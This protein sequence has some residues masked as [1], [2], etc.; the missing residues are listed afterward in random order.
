MYDGMEVTIGD[1]W[2][3]KESSWSDGDFEIPIT[4]TNI[5]NDANN[6]SLSAR[7]TW[8]PEGIA[9]LSSIGGV[10]RMRP[11]VSQETYL[12]IP[13]RGYGVYTVELFDMLRHWQRGNLFA[14]P[15]IVAAI[16]LPITRAD[17][18][19]SGTA[20]QNTGESFYAGV[21]YAGIPISRLL[22]NHIDDFIETFGFSS[23]EMH[24]SFWNEGDGIYFPDIN[25]NPNALISSV[26]FQNYRITGI[27]FQPDALELKRIPFNR[28]TL[29]LLSAFGRPALEGEG[30]GEFEGAN[31]LIYDF[32]GYSVSIW[33]YDLSDAPF[34]IYAQLN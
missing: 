28:A 10:S 20:N 31:F 19:A 22:G 34:A 17:T 3:F 9:I 25:F 6:L 7:S 2:I 18:F 8:C 1:N 14:E 16:T 4:L 26:W 27:Y 21:H 13:N 11:G 29:T 30:E 5:S 23:G 15:N 32:E 12:K 24:F 33:F